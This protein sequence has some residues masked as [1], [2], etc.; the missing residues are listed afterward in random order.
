MIY[1]IIMSI[2]S[3]RVSGCV[4]WFNNKSGYGF[5][6]AT[7]GDRQGEDVFVHH[8]A[9]NTSEE[10]YKYLV[11]GEH[12]E[13][14]W[15][16]TGDE[17]HKWTAANVN[18]INGGNLMCVTRNKSRNELSK[19]NKSDHKTRKTMIDDEGVEWLLVKKKESRK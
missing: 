17:T 11:Q 12:V 1:S 15:N 5:I 6:T 8:T 14:S 19:R 3:E 7:Q 18:G 4:K 16:D 13:F 9:L 2:D 10:Q